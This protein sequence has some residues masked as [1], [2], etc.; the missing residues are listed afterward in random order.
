LLEVLDEAV[1]PRVEQVA[2]DEIFG[3]GSRS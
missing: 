1:R 2:A 3:G